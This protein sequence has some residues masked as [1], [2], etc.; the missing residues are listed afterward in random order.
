MARQALSAADAHST[1][2]PKGKPS[3]MTGEHESIGSLSSLP[4][5]AG[6]RSCRVSKFS[7][8]HGD[9]GDAGHQR[10]LRGEGWAGAV[11]ST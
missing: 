1:L 8:D 2:G 6:A 4:W 11:P 5:R 10:A 7:G 3:V 9:V